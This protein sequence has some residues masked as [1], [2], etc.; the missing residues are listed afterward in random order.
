MNLLDLLII[1]NDSGI[2]IYHKVKN[3]LTED[4]CL[5][6]LISVFMGIINEQFIEPLERFSITS[7]DFYLQKEHKITF[8]GKFPRRLEENIVLR[9]VREIADKFF[10]NFPRELFDDWDFNVSKFLVFDAILNSP[11]SQI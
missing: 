4:D 6:G 8:I 7:F 2:M 5:G 3:P 11:I 10:R 9:E 1:A